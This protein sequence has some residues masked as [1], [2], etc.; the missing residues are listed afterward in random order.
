MS[1]IR[2]Q[3][4]W[5]LVE[6]PINNPKFKVL[7]LPG[8]MGSNLV[9]SKLMAEKNLADARIQLT[10][11]NPPGFK[12]L[13]VPKGFDFSIESFAEIVE[14]LVEKDHFDLIVGHSFSGNILIEVAAR[15]KFK[16][17]L[18]LISPSLERSAEWKDI[19]KLDGYSRKPIINGIIWAISYAMMKSVFAP[20][21][22]DPQELKDVTSDAKK[23]PRAYSRK[24]V[25]GYFDHIDK[26]GNLA[27]RLIKTNIPIYYVRGDKDDI[28]FSQENRT[29]IK[30]CKSIEIIEIPDARHFVMVDKPADIANL[31]IQILK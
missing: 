26:H 22:N 28:V 16:G 20:H 1:T 4:G 19:Q 14:K 17:I 25:I 24:T 29:I 6:T 10:A 21:F 13:P 31:I 7:L 8:L 30:S 23:N 3:D 9:F 11:G 18:M 2:E 5:I 15:N 27:K 12:G